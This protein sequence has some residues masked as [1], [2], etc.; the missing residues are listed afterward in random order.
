MLPT[1]LSQATL[2]LAGVGMIGGSVALALKSRGAVGRI[3]GFDRS[4]EGLAR[5]QQA[6]VIDE[7]AAHLKPALEQADWVILAQPVAGIVTMLPELAAALPAHSVLTDVG[8]IKGAIVSEARRVL[9]E[10]LP[11]FVPGHPLAGG[12]VS[13]VGAANGELFVGCRCALTP[14]PETDPDALAAVR[15][16]WQTIGAE[17][18][19]LDAIQHDEKLALTSHLPHVLAYVTMTQ[20]PVAER[21]LYARLA[22]GG[23]RDFTRI[24]SS[25]AE[26]WRDI[27]LLNRA[28]LLRHLRRYQTD[29][30]RMTGLLEKEDGEALQAWFARAQAARA[31]LLAEVRR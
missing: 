10:A 3:I 16:L 27:C 21:A 30:Q 19:E 24:A 4:P 18:L 5:A 26:L 17:V 7:T 25:D 28:D 29:L 8:S 9:G 11:R 22:G 15:Q 13:G 31:D 14:L 6:G 23:F 2:L 1:P 20:L 12:E